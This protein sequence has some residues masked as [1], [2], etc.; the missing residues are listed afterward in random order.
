MKRYGSLLFFSLAVLLV[1]PA[2]DVF[3]QRREASPVRLDKISENLYLIAE[4][5]GATGGAYIGDDGV[6]VID[7]KMDETSVEQTLAAIA[8]LTDK[9]VKYLF[10]T[11]SDGD[12]IAGNRYF[13]PTVTIIAS[14]NC[15]KDFFLPK[16]DGSPSDWL[17]PELA[18][19]V[20]SITFSDK[21]DIHMGSKKAELWYFGV[22]HTTGDAIAYFPEE[23]AAFLGDLVFATRPQLIHS[24]KKGNSFEYVKTMTKMLETLDAEKFCSGHSEIMDRQAIEAHIE[25]MKSRQ[26]KV[27]SLKADNKS[28]DE[29]KARFADNEGRLIE[30]IFNEI[31]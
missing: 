8:D 30:S 5:R 17:N 11:H 25:E 15:R 22:G 2:N 9:P 27:K 29:V 19:F 24:H 28:L 10:N 1:M 6:L 4:G 26:K 31:E 13:P 23:K 14:E 3:S 20:P 7:A 18:V 12:H 21:L 16:R